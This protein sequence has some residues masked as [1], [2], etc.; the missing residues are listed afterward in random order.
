VAGRRAQFRVL[1]PLEV[2]DDSG[3]TIEIGGRKQRA[4][5]AVLLLHANEVVPITRLIDDLWGEEP[6]ESAAKAVQ[7]SVSRLRKALGSSAALLETRGGGYAVRV[8]EG[9][10]DLRRFERLER[11]GRQALARGDPEGAAAR[12]DGALALWRGPPLSEFAQEA[13]GYETERLAERRLAT[14]EERLDA[15]LALGRHAALVA[16]LGHLVEEHPFRERLRGQLMLALARSGRQADAL[17]VYDEGRRRLVDELGIEPGADLRQLHGGILRQE[18]S[19]VESPRVADATPPQAP[20][21]AQPR[22]EEPLPAP[23]AKGLAQ[24]TVVAGVGLIVVVGAGVALL[25][26]L[27]GGEDAP[28]LANVVAVI[29]VREERVARAIDAGERP[30]AVA[31]GLGYVWVTSV[32]E[33]TVSRIDPATRTV[34]GRFGLG[35]EPGGLAV[36]A[37]AVWVANAAEGELVRL[38]AR[39]GAR[40]TFRIGRGGPGPV[41]VAVWADAVWV[42]NSNAFLVTRIDARANRIVATIEVDSPRFVAAGPEG[43][44]VVEVTN[45]VVELDTVTNEAG[46]RLDTGFAAGG[47]ALGAD[48]VWVSNTAEDTVHRYD[49]RTRSFRRSLDVGAGPRAL[50]FGTGSLWVANTIDGSVSR[51]DPETSDEIAVVPLGGR[52]TGLAVGAGAVWAAVAS[53]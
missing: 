38:H 7:I 9:Q 49:A 51:L 30:G 29:D 17:R 3:R 25:V 52:P 36:G 40:R 24:R 35:F 28:S 42:A 6:P 21:A 26:A 46:D 20:E 47:L 8:E 39:T 53:R 43:V 44:W 13:F 1:G 48:S 31:V 4:L 18:P 41:S 23:L 12:F 50:A 5:L 27:V 37:N 14:I 15:E 33:S 45:A 10:L 11:E 34:A 19:V 32:L 22:V 16:E 2:T